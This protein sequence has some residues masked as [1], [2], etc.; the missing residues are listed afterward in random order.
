MYER[1]PKIQPFGRRD[2]KLLEDYT[3]K[4]S[5]QHSVTV[6][7]G[8]VTD[9]ASIP[10]ALQWF[11]TPHESGIRRAAL[12]H[13]WLYA[14]HQGYS[15]GQIDKTFEKLM[16]EDGMKRYRAKLSFWTVS[17]FGKKFYMNG[18][19][20]VRSTMPDLVNHIGKTPNMEKGSKP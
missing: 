12:L 20:R 10:G 18:P 5:D 1:E 6:P 11:I 16:R 13:D 2:W 4:I 7:V 14:T 17:L 9:F 3:I 19:D 15:R 8:F